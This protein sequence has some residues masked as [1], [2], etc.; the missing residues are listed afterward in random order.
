MSRIDLIPGLVHIKILAQYATGDSN[1]AEKTIHRFVTKAPVFGHMHA[2]LC[3]VAGDHDL[4]KES[5]KGSNE[6]LN[7]I[8]IVGHVKGA[9]QYIFSGREEGKRIIRKANNTTLD[10]A[11]SVPLVGHG[12]AG[13]HYRRGDKERAKRVALEATRTTVVLA[14]GAAGFGI[15]GPPGAIALGMGAGTQWDLGAAGLS[16]GKYANGLGKIVY[17]PKNIDAYIETGLRVVGDGLNGYAGGKIADRVQQASVIGTADNLKK[18]RQEKGFPS[19]GKCPPP[20]AKEVYSEVK[21]LNNGN[22]YFGVNS[23][24]RRAYQ[25]PSPRVNKFV[26]QHSNINPPLQRPPYTCAEAQAYHKFVVDNPNSSTLNT[27]LNTLEVKPNGEI[28]TIP[29]CE[30][31]QAYKDVAGLCRTDVNPHRVPGKYEF[32][33]QTG[34]AAGTDHIIRQINTHEK[35][36]S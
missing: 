26:E 34:P 22:R 12:I 30:N 33:G 10:I 6:S 31:C 27:R 1:G 24:A 25:D 2:G 7:S 20:S 32:V 36:P 14:A 4:A 19:D 29:R 23:R 18:L 13:Y 5:W 16:D 17:E 21:D 8:P 28:H 11:G 35:R 9:G 3:K 15:G